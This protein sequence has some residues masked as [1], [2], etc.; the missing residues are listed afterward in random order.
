MLRFLIFNVICVQEN[1]LSWRY[2]STCKILNF[3]THSSQ[4][5]CLWLK[6]LYAI[7]KHYIANHTISYFVPESRASLKYA[8]QL[9]FTR[10][11]YHFPFIFLQKQVISHR[12]CWKTLCFEAIHLV[13]CLSHSF[14][15][16]E[17]RMET[18]LLFLRL[19][20]EV[21]SCFYKSI[22]SHSSS[23]DLL[24][25]SSAW[26]WDVTYEEMISSEE[27]KIQQRRRNLGSNDT[28]YMQKLQYLGKQAQKFLN[29][30]H[31]VIRSTVLSVN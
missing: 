25:I 5:E 7:R 31:N 6:F 12:V 21:F 29:L 24:I 26:D 23:C 18:I 3:Y 16:K 28:I 19:F 14:N 30:H 13:F 10:Y 11:L 22:L 1:V 17:Y 2:K 15:T 8:P 20:L 4:A 9:W 27:E